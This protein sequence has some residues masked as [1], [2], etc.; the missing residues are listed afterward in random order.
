MF[1]ML[2]PLK[3]QAILVNIAH[4]NSVK[5][6]L[7]EKND[8]SMQRCSVL[9]LS[10]RM[11]TL[12]ITE[13][14][15]QIRHTIM[16]MSSHFIDAIDGAGDPVL[17]NSSLV[18]YIL[19]QKTTNKRQRLISWHSECHFTDD[20]PALLITT[21]LHQ[22]QLFFKADTVSLTMP[23]GAQVLVQ[24]SLIRWIAHCPMIDANGQIIY[25]SRLGFIQQGHELFVST[26]IDELITLTAKAFIK[27]QFF[28]VGDKATEERFINPAMV[29]SITTGRHLLPQSDDIVWLTKLT[30]IGTGDAFQVSDT[31]LYF[32]N[33]LSNAFPLFRPFLNA[34]NQRSMLINTEHIESVLPSKQVNED[35]EGGYQIALYYTIILAFGSSLTLWSEPDLTALISQLFSHSAIPLLTLTP[36]TSVSD[37]PLLIN[38]Q[39]VV[40]VFINPSDTATS[41]LVLLSSHDPL[42]VRESLSKIK[43]LLEPADN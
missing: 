17:I 1:V 2:H 3:E 43:T 31:M 28:Y 10:F 15:E 38:A 29:T 5:P 16:A 12:L 7:I 27:V 30:F 33:L 34:H 11:S 37:L 13:P 24:T 9:S 4:I 18:T 40:V 25:G 39:Q 14:I 35:T 23:H 6:T 42:L 8:G 32:T 41:Q 20:H 22:L 21:P 26:S 19:A 36:E